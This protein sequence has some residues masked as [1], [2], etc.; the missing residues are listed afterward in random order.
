H[1][2]QE[3]EVVSIRARRSTSNEQ[4]HARSRSV[5]GTGVTGSFRHITRSTPTRWL[6]FSSRLDR[7]RPGAVTWSTR[8]LAVRRPRHHAAVVWLSAAPGP[9]CIKAAKS[10]P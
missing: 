6:T 8:G 10:R 7:L 1:R 2:G 3:L 4:T 5:R 9:A